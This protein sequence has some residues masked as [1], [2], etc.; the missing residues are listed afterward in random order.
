MHYPRYQALE[1]RWPGLLLQAAFF[2]CC[3]TT[4]VHSWPVWPLRGYNKTTW[5]VKPILTADLVS[6]A[7]CASLGHLLMVQHCHLCLYICFSL[8]TAPH[9]P[10]HPHLPP[11]PL[12]PT[13]PIDSIH[14]ITAVKKPPKKRGAF[15]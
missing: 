8:P 14:D 6:P 4:R 13:H 2:L 15:K 11:H 3:K 12:P 9:P 5:G 10:T 1:T 7:S